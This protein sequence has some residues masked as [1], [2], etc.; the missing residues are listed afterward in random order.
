VN[1]AGKAKIGLYIAAIFV[2]GFI[3]GAYVTIQVGRHMMPG[4]ADMADRYCSDL[5]TRLNLT[6][7]QVEKIHPIIT[8]S[9]GEF[10]NRLSVDMEANMSNCNARIA[11]NLT[12]DQLPKFEVIKKEQTDMIGAAFGRATNATNHP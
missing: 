7:A 12:P 4:P 6:S 5:Q 2:A 8:D 11:V 1:S 10:K 3:S 9:M